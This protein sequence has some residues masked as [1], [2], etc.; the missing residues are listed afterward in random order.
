[1]AD[2]YKSL[3]SRSAAITSDMAESFLNTVQLTGLD[4]ETRE[5]LDR[6]I[7][8]DGI[9]EAISSLNTG[10]SPGPDGLSPE[11]SYSTVWPPNC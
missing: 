6:P 10:K 3:Y 9:V 7:T 8:A 5:E 1:M 11:L 4:R 2:F